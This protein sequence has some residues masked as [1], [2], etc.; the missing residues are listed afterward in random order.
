VLDTM[1]AHVADHF[2]GAAHGQRRFAGD[3]AGQ[4]HDALVQRL[5]IGVDAVH[6]ADALRFLGVHHAAGVGQLAHHAVADDA[7][8]TLQGANVGGHAHVDLLDGE[9]GVGCGVAHVAGG[10]HVDGAADAVALD[11]GQHRLAAPVDGV[12]GGLQGED[13]AADVLGLATDVAAAVVSR[14]GQHLQVD[15]GGEVLA[16]PADDHHANFAGLVDPFEDVHDLRPEI[17]VHGVDLL[18]TVDHHLGDL[19]GH[20]DAE[21]FVFGLHNEP[22]RD[23]R[24]CLDPD[25]Y[26][27]LAGQL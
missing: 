24:G 20:F 6:Q 27:W 1:V 25:S 3:F 2:L 8:Q 16:G 23:G 7:R 17:G 10:D 14:P 9:L 13:L 12:E 15:P 4:R 19:I 11:G 21:G 22:R 26:E 5:A 18:R